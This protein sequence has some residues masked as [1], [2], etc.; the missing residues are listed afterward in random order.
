MA[1]RKGENHH[2]RKLTKEDVSIIRTSLHLPN[3]FFAKSL[4]VSDAAISLVRSGKT[5]KV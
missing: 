5:W 4:G 3:R 2:K 1:A